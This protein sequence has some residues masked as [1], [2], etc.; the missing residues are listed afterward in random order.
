MKNI[1]DTRWGAVSAAVLCNLLWGSAYPAIKLGYEQFDITGSVPQKLF[2]AGL[3][4]V[5]AGVMVLAT[6]AVFNR[7]IPRL[8][9]GN[10]RRIAL[11][12]LV[13]TALQYV[14]FYIGLSNTTGS[15][16]SIVNSSTTF[17]ALIAGH[18]ICGERLDMKKISGAVIGFAGVVTV[19]VADGAGGVSFEGEGFILIAAACFVAGSMLS[20]R[21]VSETDAMT[22]T[23]Y[24]LLIGGA[25]LTAAG[26]AGGGV[27][28]T[29]TASGAAILFY[30]AF[31]SAAAFTLWTML[32]RRC[33]VGRISVFNF[34]IPV[35]GTVLSAVFMHENIFSIR[36]MVSLI[37]VCAGIIIV[38]GAGKTADMRRE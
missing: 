9:K 14:F 30:L 17:M 8:N 11:I 37:L 27:L 20:K 25:V 34:I 7:R 36:Y 16:G 5:L 18:F 2:F 4:F 32:L 24:N 15:N 22:V 38:N 33:E 10:I 23:G 21:A 29:V 31:L 3:R 28:K 26:A 19:L 6:G 1:I 35:S 12:G 13:Y